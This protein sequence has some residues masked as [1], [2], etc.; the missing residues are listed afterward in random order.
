MLEIM[1][2]PGKLDHRKAFLKSTLQGMAKNR[3][4]CR[5]GPSLKVKA[6]FIESAGS[7]L[8]RIVSR[9]EVCPSFFFSFL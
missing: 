8:Y 2:F 9:S 7:Y 5:K 1:S 4:F 6:T 3:L